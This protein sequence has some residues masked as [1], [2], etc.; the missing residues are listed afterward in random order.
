[1]VEN[2]IF[3]LKNIFIFKKYFFTAL[4]II[5]GLKIKFDIYGFNF[6]NDFIYL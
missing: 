5:L 4:N 2:K 3:N 6:G 1:M